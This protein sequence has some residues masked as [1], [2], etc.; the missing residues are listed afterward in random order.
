MKRSIPAML[1]AAILLPAAVACTQDVSAAEGCTNESCFPQRCVVV[2]GEAGHCE[3]NVG[4]DG[5]GEG[6]APVVGGEGEGEGAGGPIGGGE[7]EGQP[8]PP[9]D[10]TP[11]FHRGAFTGGAGTLHSASFTL[12]GALS[13]SFRN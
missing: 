7:G 8:P 11:H 1:L 6:A 13:S 4:A 5:E 10:T 9:V 12:T 3:G 2:E